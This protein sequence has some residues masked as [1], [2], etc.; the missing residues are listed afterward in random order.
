MDSP[1]SHRGPPV[2]W[3]RPL[4]ADEDPMSDSPPIRTPVNSVAPVPRRIRGYLAGATVVD[5]TRARY[6]WEVPSYP[7][8][9]LPL[10]DIGP[11]LLVDEGRTV[12]TPRGTARV[13]GVRVGDTSRPSS[14][15]VYD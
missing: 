6:V 1:V 13:H 15:L 11:D 2:G 8:Y 3:T 7:Q 5:T 10:A 9:H 12:E 4:P 14:V